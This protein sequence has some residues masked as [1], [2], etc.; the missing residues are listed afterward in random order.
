MP[1]QVAEYC[2]D[3]ADLTIEQVV[4]QLK[5]PADIIWFFSLNGKKT[6]SNYLLKPGDTLTIH[7]PVDG[8]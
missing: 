6:D 3:F 5:L 7:S 4:Q 2:S 1:G 8:G